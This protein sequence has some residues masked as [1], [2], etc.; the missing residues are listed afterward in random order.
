MPWTVQLRQF[1]Y[2][3]LELQRLLE[4]KKLSEL[5]KG[6]VI[7][8][9]KTTVEQG[10][11]TLQSF[12][13][14]QSS[15]SYMRPYSLRDAVERQNFPI[16]LGEDLDLQFDKKSF[17][18]MEWEIREIVYPAFRDL[19]MYLKTAEKQLQQS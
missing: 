17:R 18:E 1:E 15:A 7:P 13:K 9:L 5:E 6:N 10:W 16:K 12:S 2:S 19:Y 8:I 3:F 14:D 11:S 4:K